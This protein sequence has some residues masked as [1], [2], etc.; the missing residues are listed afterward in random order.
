MANTFKN[1]TSKSVG[2]AAASVVTAPAGTA[3]TVIGMTVCNT[4]TATVKASIA[5]TESSTDYYILG[6]A[7]PATNGTSIAPGDSLIVF[8]GDQKLVLEATNVLKVISSAAASLDVIVS[9]LEI[10]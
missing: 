5:L 4:S 10:T 2:T 3:V 7:A 6:S 8:G 1:Y 9:V